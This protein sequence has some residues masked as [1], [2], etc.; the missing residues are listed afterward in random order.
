MV[1][2]TDPISPRVQNNENLEPTNTLPVLSKPGTPSSSG[3]TPL[4]KVSK[5]TSAYVKNSLAASKVVEFVPEKVNDWQVAIDQA[6]AYK[7]F[8][9]KQR[10]GGGS[11]SNPKGDADLTPN[12]KE[13]KDD[14][15]QE[16]YRKW[17]KKQERE[18]LRKHVKGKK[19]R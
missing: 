6:A 10:E 5:K 4:S 1:V 17:K 11:A 18:A 16:A 2:V 9:A 15:A 13:R 3:L 7:K 8:K 12:T 19:V 14:E